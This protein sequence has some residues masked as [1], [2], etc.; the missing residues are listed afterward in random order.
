MRI[1]MEIE[2]VTNKS[3]QI[4][5]TESVWIVDW[6]MAF[7]SYHRHFM[8]TNRSR[9][10][11]G[12]SFFFPRRNARIFLSTHPCIV[13]ASWS[14]IFFY[15]TSSLKGFKVNKWCKSAIEACWRIS[16]FFF[17]TKHRTKNGAPKRN[18]R[19]KIELLLNQTFWCFSS[20][21]LIGFYHRFIAELGN[22]PMPFD[23]FDFSFIWDLV[24]FS[25]DLCVEMLISDEMGLCLS[26]W[27]WLFRRKIV[28]INGIIRANAH[29]FFYQ[30][31][32]TWR[33]KKKRI[34]DKCSEKDNERLNETSVAHEDI[35]RRTQF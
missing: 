19:W 11:F 31:N 5:R 1:A 27:W 6:N 18:S 2:R 14:Y 22:P 10:S 20:V 29:F 33:K 35:K 4:I 15:E 24:E 13:G 25:L 28:H 30:H 34:S 16:S 3:A 26:Y 7:D 12:R 9:V 8:A 17:S 23:A 21:N 32:I